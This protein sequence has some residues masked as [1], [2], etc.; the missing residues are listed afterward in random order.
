MDDKPSS[1]KDNVVFVA[2]IYYALVCSA[3]SGWMIYLVSGFRHLNRVTDQVDCIIIIIMCLYK[4]MEGGALALDSKYRSSVIRKLDL[5][6]GESFSPFSPVFLNTLLIIRF[7]AW[8]EQL[9]TRDESTNV[10][11]CIA[12][13]VFTTIDLTILHPRFLKDTVSAISGGIGRLFR[14][15]ESRGTKGNAERDVETTTEARI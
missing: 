10:K 9:K 13:I 2:G 14:K 11:F 1:A 15:G 3:L 4:F 6:N 8:I 5:G 7:F 12:C